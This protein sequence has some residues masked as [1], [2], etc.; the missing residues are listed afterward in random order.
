MCLIVFLLT[1]FK[2]LIMLTDEIHHNTTEQRGS[3]HVTLI[4][5]PCR[6]IRPF[7]ILLSTRGDNGPYLFGQDV[8]DPFKP[9]S[10]S[11]TK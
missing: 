5:F 11:E 2:T 9:A 1:F 7:R 10:S 8:D 6:H 4:R 3:S